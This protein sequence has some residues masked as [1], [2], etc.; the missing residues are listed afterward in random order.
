[1]KDELKV[2]VLLP[3]QQETEMCP[4]SDGRHQHPCLVLSQQSAV[5]ADVMTANASQQ[6]LRTRSPPPAR[7]Y[8]PILFYSPKAAENI[9]DET[10]GLIPIF[11]IIS[12]S[13]TAIRV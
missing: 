2:K 4:A 11:L 9:P 7:R 13:L 12:A 3:S 5:R 10:E 8:A 6:S 1:M